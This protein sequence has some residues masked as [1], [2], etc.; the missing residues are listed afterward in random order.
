MKQSQ[1]VFPLA[2][3]SAIMQATVANCLGHLGRRDTNRNDP[4]CVPTPMV[5]KANTVC[6]CRRRFRQNL[7]MY[8][9]RTFRLWSR[10]KRCHEPSEERVDHSKVA[11]KFKLLLIPYLYGLPSVLTCFISLTINN[12]TLVLKNVS[13]KDLIN[14]K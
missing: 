9:S 14:S 6:R 5:A 13:F 7:A 10:Y 3:F 2:K 1:A 11:F 4:V 8:K 12:I